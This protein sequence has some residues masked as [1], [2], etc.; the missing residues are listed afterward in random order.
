MSNYTIPSAIDAMEAIQSKKLF[1]FDLVYTLF[2]SNVGRITPLPSKD[3]LAMVYAPRNLKSQVESV[4]FYLSPSCV[5]FSSPCVHEM[6]IVSAVM[7]PDR[8]SLKARPCLGSVANSTKKWSENYSVSFLFVDL[9]LMGNELV[10]Y[11][12][13]LLADS[14][15]AVRYA[16]KI[17]S[18][19]RDAIGMT[20][21]ESLR[22]FKTTAEF[23]SHGADVETLLQKNMEE[24]ARQRSHLGSHTVSL[25]GKV[26][27][28]IH[29]Q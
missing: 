1:S 26:I 29:D 13:E 14:T 10:R 28:F 3:N 27:S 11:S 21:G 23:E 7:N 17:D 18:G 9:L 6:S 24:V 16:K 12:K 15:F 25:D 20:L 5:E 4:D 8:A 19:L 22:L 2:L